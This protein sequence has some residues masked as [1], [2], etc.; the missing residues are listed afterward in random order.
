MNNYWPLDV[1]EIFNRYLI[2]LHHLDSLDMVLFVW[3]SV[4]GIVLISI[5]IGIATSLFLY[6]YIQTAYEYDRDNWNA[7]NPFRNN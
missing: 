1:I 2:K 7:Y 3:F 5:N 4:W 6:I